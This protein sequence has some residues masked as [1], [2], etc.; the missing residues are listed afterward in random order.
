MAT[1]IST[2]C[3]DLFY[4]IVEEADSGKTAVCTLVLGDG[5]K[6]YF[7]LSLIYMIYDVLDKLIS[8]NELFSFS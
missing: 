1:H 6:Y 2:L 8:L 5:Q 4:N 7:L 3:Y